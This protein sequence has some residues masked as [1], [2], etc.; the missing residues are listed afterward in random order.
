MKHSH[1]SENHSSTGFHEDNFFYVVQT[2]M[3]RACK[4]GSDGLFRKTADQ[5]IAKL[6]LKPKSDDFLNGLMF[7]K[8]FI[9]LKGIYKYTSCA[10]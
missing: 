2:K 8:P 9:Y 7:P 10:R 4:L 3:V 6:A 1:T 5:A